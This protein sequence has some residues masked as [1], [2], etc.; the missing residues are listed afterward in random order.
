MKIFIDTANI[1]EIKE[2]SEMGFLA[3]VT[4]NPTLI[5]KEG[6]DY[7]QVI[8]EICAI[9]NGPISA[10]V[11]SLDYQTMIKEG[12]ELAAIHPNVVIKVPLS[13]TG[14]KVI[15]AFKGLG[16]ATNATLIFSAHQALLAARSGASYVSPF[17][18]RV[19]DVGNSGLILLED[20]MSVFDQYALDT[21]VIAASIRHP[22]HVLECARLG[23]H[24][25]TIPY[26]VIKQMIKHPLTDAGIERFMND[27]KQVF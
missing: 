25:A 3:G 10:E 19:D 7:H 8:Q 14:L 21:E 18:G 27:W 1:E 13:E 6:R 20:I 11:I 5:A 16:I 26:S 15:H 4:T 12:Q 23:A 22:L 17:L 2:I 9:V 24:I